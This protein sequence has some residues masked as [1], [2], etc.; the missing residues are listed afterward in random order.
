MGTRFNGALGH[1]GCCND[2]L[3]Y[4]QKYPLRE[5]KQSTLALCSEVDRLKSDFNPGLNPCI[6]IILFFIP[7]SA[8]LLRKTGLLF[9]GITISTCSFSTGALTL[10]SPAGGWAP[11]WTSAIVQPNRPA[12]NVPSSLSYLLLSILTYQM[13][14]CCCFLTRRPQSSHIW[15]EAESA[16]ESAR[17]SAVLPA[18][19]GNK[20]QRGKVRDRVL[21]LFP[22]RNEFWYRSQ[23]SITWREGLRLQAVGEPS[24]CRTGWRAAHSQLLSAR[25]RDACAS[26]GPALATRFPP[27]T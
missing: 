25:R 15:V 27:L 7:T 19:C 26:R 17:I 22:F 6:L 11:H 20:N 3:K 4:N 13:I 24:Q 1:L 18:T 5:R 12:A 2:K 8:L 9:S 14:F 21:H 23:L 16:I 10:R